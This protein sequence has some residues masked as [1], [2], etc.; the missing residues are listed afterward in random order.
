MSSD[1]AVM[2]TGVL[3]WRLMPGMGS[4]ILA[5]ISNTP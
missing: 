3:G 1:K 5:V 2:G 4:P